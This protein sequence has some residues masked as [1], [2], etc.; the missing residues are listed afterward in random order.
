MKHLTNERIA[1]GVTVVTLLVLLII[2]QFTA[3]HPVRWGTVIDVSDYPDQQPWVCVKN[4]LQPD[5]YPVT[6]KVYRDCYTGAYWEVDHCEWR[7]WD[8]RPDPPPVSK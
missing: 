5:C 2:P 8:Q 3:G 7:D 1:W 4:H 6:P